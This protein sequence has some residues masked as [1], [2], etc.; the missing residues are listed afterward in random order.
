MRSTRA[1]DLVTSYEAEYQGQSQA[2]PD[3][4]GALGQLSAQG[5]EGFSRACLTLR[6]R[7]G[8]VVTHLSLCLAN[9]LLILSLIF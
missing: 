3:G 6:F 1:T 4:D 8:G 9:Q 5:P 2:D 7:V